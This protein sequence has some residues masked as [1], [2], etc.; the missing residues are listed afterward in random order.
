MKSAHFITAIGTP[1]TEDEALHEQGLG[2]HLADQRN[3]HIDGILVG[4]TMGAMQLLTDQTY[5]R[6]VRRAV[7]LWTGHGEIFVG[8][9][10][11]GLTR[12]RERIL[13]LNQC[14]ID[15]A[16]VLAP[17]FWT[18]SQKE[19]IDYYRA[20][21]D[22]STAPLYL[23]DLPQVTG[24]KLEMDTIVALADHPNIRGVKLSCELAFTR[25]LI[26]LVG[27]SLR[28]L[29]AQPDLVDLLLRQGVSQHLDGMWAIAPGWTVELGRCASRGNWAGAA[30]YQQNITNLRNLIM[31]FGLGVFTE[32][33]NARG[34][35]GIFAPR[36]F[37]RLD[38]A[39]RRS[40][41]KEPVVEK[42]IREDP[43]GTS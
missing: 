37:A 19:L 33:M 21:A 27:D 14:Q 39:A 3:A 38:D 31:K 28:V 15:G 7:E 30:E 20:L 26:D 13:F 12:T 11:T 9:G 41:L 23:Y 35:S 34:I 4:G 6:L 32:L 22:I 18:F 36:P 5:R 1:L 16:A 10:D 43:A 42:L 17:Y 40:L 29:V 25:R 2:A 8:A 24:T